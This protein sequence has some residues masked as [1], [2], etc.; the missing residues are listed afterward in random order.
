MAGLLSLHGQSS[1]RATDAR[2]MEKSTMVG[3]REDFS[4]EVVGTEELLSIALDGVL[5]GFEYRKRFFAEHP[6]DRILLFERSTGSGRPGDRA[7][8][9]WSE[10]FGDRAVPVPLVGPELEVHRHDGE[11]LGPETFTTSPVNVPVTRSP[12]IYQPRESDP[13]LDMAFASGVVHRERRSRGPSAVLVTTPLT[14]PTDAAVT[15]RDPSGRSYRIPAGETFALEQRFRVGRRPWPY[16]FLAGPIG[17]QQEVNIQVV[18]PIFLEL[19]PVG[20]RSFRLDVINSGG[21]PIRGQLEFSLLDAM[22]EDTAPFTFPLTMA[23]GE[24]VTSLELPLEASV[25]LDRPLQVRLMA[26]LPEDPSERIVL[27]ESKA[28]R[29]IFAADFTKVDE[30]GALRWYKLREPESG[31]AVLSTGVPRDEAL[32]EPSLGAAVMVYTFAEAAGTTSLEPVADQ[33]KG[34]IA[35]PDA[36]GVWLY[37]D[38]SGNMVYPELVDATKV[39]KKI[40]PVALTWEGWRYQQ[41]LLPS[42]LVPPL[43]WKSLLTI[44]RSPNGGSRGA[45]FINHPTLVYAFDP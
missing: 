38:G 32:P 27:S 9:V 2:G 33:L 28:L 31:I 11:S 18:N 24:N 42:E 16:R 10:D 19:W 3:V 13:L 45:V 25:Q 5:R 43:Q 6:T 36:I 14:N 39:S 37:S 35:V 15:V 7:V 17:L 8:V 29:F 20:E 22:G 12:L 1:P 21:Q 30:T 41:F 26:R 4:T 23:A 34:I 44:E 40:A